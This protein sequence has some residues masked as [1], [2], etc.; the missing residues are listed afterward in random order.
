[1]VS[2]LASYSDNPSSNAA[3]GYSLLFG[4]A[5][6]KEKKKQIANGPLRKIPKLKGSIFFYFAGSKMHG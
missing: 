4:K 1:M 3:E 6:W 5:V 2:M